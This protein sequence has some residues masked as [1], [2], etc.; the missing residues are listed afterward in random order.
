MNDEHF[1]INNPA[2]EHPKKKANLPPSLLSRRPSIHRFNIANEE[3]AKPTHQKKRRLTTDKNY[4]M[5]PNSSHSILF[6]DERETND[7]S[8]TTLNLKKMKENSKK[9]KNQEKKDLFCQ[10]DL[11]ICCTYIHTYLVPT[12]YTYMRS[13]CP[14]SL[15]LSKKNSEFFFLCIPPMKSRIGEERKG[16]GKKKKKKKR[17]DPFHILPT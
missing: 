7:R 12:Y 13:F 11:F 10:F 2:T 4:A 5:K 1:R 6:Y 16:K 8:L 15:F 3:K 14:L 9:T 17:G